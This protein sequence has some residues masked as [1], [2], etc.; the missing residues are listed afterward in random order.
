MIKFNLNLKFKF[1]IYDIFLNSVVYAVYKKLA[2]NVYN[3]NMS[4]DSALM[5]K[6]YSCMPTYLGLI[7]YWSERDI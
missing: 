6:T 3:I 2:F 7:T 5:I 4:K 1:H